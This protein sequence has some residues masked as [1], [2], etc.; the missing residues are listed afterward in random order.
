[1]TVE[2]SDSNARPWPFKKIASTQHVTDAEGKYTVEIPPEQSSIR[3]LYIQIYAEH[4]EFVRYSG[5]Y[6]LSMIRK[7]ET[8]GRRPFFER[9]K[10]QPGHPITGK[11][12]APSGVPLAGA[13]LFGF[14]NMKPHDVNNTAWLDGQTASDG[15]FRLNKMKGGL[16]F[17]WVL[18]ND[19]AIVQRIVNQGDRD[20]G[21]I[22][23]AAGSR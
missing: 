21:E 22:R 23:Q 6:S 9:L 13:K 10:L 12:I 16:A 17:V 2:R 4:D 8:V 1:V 15:S 5:G 14:T 19:Y 3:S 20:L 11:V 7:N 18:P